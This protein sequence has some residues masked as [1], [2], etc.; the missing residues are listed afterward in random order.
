MAS[1]VLNSKSTVVISVFKHHYRVVP[2]I[3]TKFRAETED[4][5]NE[6]RAKQN[7]NISCPARSDFPVFAGE[8]E[9]LT[10]TDQ[11]K[12]IETLQAETQCRLAWLTVA[13]SDLSLPYLNCW[14]SGLLQRI[15]NIKHL[16]PNTSSFQFQ[17]PEENPK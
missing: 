13:G 5:W 6:C 14:L 16:W 7:L 15:F 3:L 2:E 12:S 8:Y 10:R 1:M 4:K 17:I 9:R 11:G